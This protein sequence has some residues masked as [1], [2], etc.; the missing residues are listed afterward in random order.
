MIRQAQTQDIGRIA[1]ILVFGKRTAY[2]DIFRDD[3]GTFQTLSVLGTVETYQNDP[4]L[5]ARTLVYDDGVVKGLIAWEPGAPDEIE[6]CDF[7]VDPFFKGLGI[8]R[9]LMD[10]FLS[11]AAQAGKKRV[12]LWV[13]KENKPARHFYGLNGFMADGQ[14]KNVP[15]TGIVQMRYA[16][17]V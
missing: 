15:S 17:E 11:A 16:R 10:R 9:A 1:E 3:I 2:R 5:L 14:L 6:L 12:Y 7:Y 4:L 13:L 8:G